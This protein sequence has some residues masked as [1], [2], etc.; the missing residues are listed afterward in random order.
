MVTCDACLLMKS[1]TGRSILIHSTNLSNSANHATNAL[2]FIQPVSIRLM[3]ALG[4]AH[5]ASAML[6]VRCFPGYMNMGGIK[7]PTAFTH[8]RTVICSFVPGAH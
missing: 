3:N 5:M 1:M 8:P 4:N 2:P 6:R 7:S